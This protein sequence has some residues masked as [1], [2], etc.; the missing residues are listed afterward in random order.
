MKK[1]VFLKL[2]SALL[3]LCLAST[4]AIGTTFAKYT[5]A[6]SAADTARVAKWG[7]VVSTSGTL[8]GKYY[9]A[10][11]ATDADKIVA[12][13]AY[14]VDTSDGA[15]IVAP[16]T[17]ND[18]G[19]QVLVN[20]DPEVAYDVLADNG[21]GTTMEDIWLKAGNYG[22]MVL[23]HGIN[24]ATDFSGNDIY[25]SEDAQNFTRVTTWEALTGS[26]KYYR[27]HDVAT[28]ATDYYPIVW[29]VAKIGTAPDLTNTHLATADGTAGIAKEI[30]NNL[31]ALSGKANDEINFGYTLTWEWK[32]SDGNDALDTILGNLSA[33]DA[34]QVV[35]KTT[36]SG[37]T[38][39]KV[40]A[41]DYNLDINFELNVT[42]NQVD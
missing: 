21:T 16:G 4:C 42:V 3:V 36:D 41:S 11:S 8:F 20:G 5:T 27:L 39:A 12:N 18:T 34:D 30:A 7:M 17:K 22:V 37:A 35:V 26:Y 1:N 38:Y 14:S 15:K 10:H 13:V 31:T 2:A 29:T 40:A 25:K 23:A 6:D 33:A 24:P 19:F 32:F 9:A 28:T